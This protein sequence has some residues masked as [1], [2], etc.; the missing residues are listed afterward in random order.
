MKAGGRRSNFFISYLSSWGGG[1]S[2]SLFPSAK[3][4]EQGRGRIARGMM[5]FAETW[6]HR[7]TSDS[8]TALEALQK[9]CGVQADR[10]NKSGRGKSDVVLNPPTQPPLPLSFSFFFFFDN[11]RC[12]NPG[13]VTAK[14]CICGWDDE[15]LARGLKQQ[16]FHKPLLSLLPFRSR[17]MQMLRVMSPTL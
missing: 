15:P 7:N 1:C 3:N 10:R 6:L 9:R 14:A 2:L 17:L 11:N 16:Y 4:N 13:C 8:A 12:C 5:C